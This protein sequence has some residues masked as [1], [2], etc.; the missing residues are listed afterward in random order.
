MSYRINKTNGD[1]I[2]ELADG[3]IDTTSTDVT[4]VGRNYRGFGELFNENFVKIVENFASSGEPNNPLQGQ[5]W[6]DTALQRLKIYNGTEFRTA[7]AP[8]V[9]STQPDLV[10]GDIWIDSR[11]K[12]LYFYDGNAAGNITLVGPAYDDAQ[13]KS[14]IEVESTIDISGQEQVIVKFYVANQLA[15]VLTNDN[16]RLA[17][18]NKIEEYPDDPNDL[19]VPA[20]QLFQ[21][22]FNPVNSE[23]WFRGT[24]ETANGLVD[25]EGNI[26]TTAS[27]IPSDRDGETIGSITIKNSQGLALGIDDT[28]YSRLR[29]VG[30]STVF[31]TRQSATDLILQ[32]R[33]GNADINSFF[34][35]GSDSSIGINTTSPTATLDVNGSLTVRQNTVIDGDLTVN[36][37][38]TYV[39]VDTL[40]VLDKNIELGLLDDSTQGS[41]NDVDGAGI[42]VSS[43]QGSKDLYWDQSSNSWTSNVNLN[44]LLGNEFRINDQLILSRTEL[45]PTVSTAN[46]LSSIGTLVSLNVDNINLDGSAI[47]TSSGGLTL[48]PTGDITVSNSKITDLANPDNNQDA[49][50]KLYVDTEIRSTD[51]ALSLDT[52]GLVDPTPSNPYNQVSDILESIS[53]AGQKENGV[54]ARIHCVNYNNTTVSDINIQDAADISRISVISD[55]SSAVSVVEDITFSLAEGNVNLTPNRQ[56]MIF[57]VSNGAWDWVSTN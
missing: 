40:R 52:T 17:G 45:G 48:N 31:G 10:E 47:S 43:S 15:F 22:G 14:G 28:I 30:T 25:D 26:R 54:I 12:K 53:P 21:K 39:N 2:V 46:G 24:A 19:V 13:G 55:D 49:T 9:S 56:T 3:T 36:G 42:T 35:R 11:N 20:R 32:T 4:L 37:S 41:D 29:T 6:Y 1:L 34:I 57:Q 18:R 16:F 27:F 44:L 7:G 5:L 33:Q 8:V 38:A 50:T 51:V 23:L